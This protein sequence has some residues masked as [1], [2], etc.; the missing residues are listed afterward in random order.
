MTFADVDQRY[1]ALKQQ[2]DAGDLTEEEFDDALRALMVQDEL[3]RWWAKARDSGQWNYYDAVTQTWKPAAPPQPTAPPVM[4]PPPPAQS[5][6]RSTTS[7]ASE[8]GM[9]EAQ[10]AQPAAQW[11]GG[12]VYTT[13]QPELSPGLKV[14]FYILSFLVPIVGI[15]LFFVYRGKPAP[16]D[17]AAAKLFLILGV[18]AFAL[19]CVCPLVFSVFLAML[20]PLSG[21]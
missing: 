9:V 7:Q 18:I 10:G 13:G 17:R 14:V 16:E 15:V 20:A 2:F 11:P 4:P 19:S 12:T 3:G 1:L 21:A 5:F 6:E 8:P